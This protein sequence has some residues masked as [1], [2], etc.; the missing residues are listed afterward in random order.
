[1][2]VHIPV[3]RTHLPRGHIF[4]APPVDQTEQ[5]QPNAPSVLYTPQAH[6]YAGKGTSSAI[7]EHPIGDARPLKVVISM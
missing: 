5:L 2:V 6:S 1:M 7:A 3:E 4:D